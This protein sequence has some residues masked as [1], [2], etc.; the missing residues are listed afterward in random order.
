[1]NGANLFGEF[2]ARWRRVPDAP[3]FLAADGRR[4]ATYGDL[5]AAAG[6]YAGALRDLGVGPGDRVTAQVEK[7]LAAVFLYLG[8]LKSGAVLQPLNPAYTPAEVSYFIADAEPSLVVA[9]TAKR[10]PLA[11]L[12]ARHSAAFATLDDVD[13]G[14]LAEA[15]ARAGPLDATVDRTGDGLAGLLYTSGTTGPAKGAMITHGN[16]SSN[17]HAL[18]GAWAFAPGDVLIHGLPLFHV[19]GLYVALNTAFLNASP[20][21]W[22]PHFDAAEVAR[23]FARATLFMGVPTY[24]TRLLAE[25]GLDAGACQAMRLFVSGSAPLLPE[26]HDAFRERTGH[27]I[28]ERY[29]M[30][31]TGMIA[32]NPYRGDRRPGTVGFALPGIAVR[33]CDVEGRERPRGEPGV[34]EVKGP[35]VCR[36]YWRKPE[37]TAEDF[38]SDGYFVT[39]DVGVMDGEGRVS[40]LG[41]TRD[42]IITG[43]LNVY[44]REI[45]AALDA[46]PGIVESAVVGVPHPD[47]GEGVV[48]AVVAGHE[49]I[50]EAAIIG[51]LAATLAGFKLPKRV[52]RIAELP[53]NA[54][55]KIEKAKLR[56]RFADAFRV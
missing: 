35:N 8:A 37:R 1:M 40:I 27:A 10:E 49:P 26:T 39:G 34:L 52:Y 43:G 4:L 22:L 28:L 17:A 14:S 3:A 31:E 7:S 48:A 24:Y 50:D 2:E 45:E 9:A 11:A 30:T 46:L 6:R 56:K 32:S 15:A 54:M 16:L 42:L 33:V 38:R 12:A 36:G 20:I 19:H 25:P 53:R 21:L 55:G 18:L 13:A 5:M 29:G 51:A 47:Y 23:L 41:R 44:P